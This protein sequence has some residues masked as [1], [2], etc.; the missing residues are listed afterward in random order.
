MRRK[1]NYFLVASRGLRFVV[2]NSESSPYPP[3]L[4]CLIGGFY[5][6]FRQSIFRSGGYGVCSRVT[7]VCC[8]RCAGTYVRRF[9]LVFDVGLRVLISY[10]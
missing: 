2:T 6:P 7:L 8:R 10:F 3:P 5:V 1:K 9:V 4:L